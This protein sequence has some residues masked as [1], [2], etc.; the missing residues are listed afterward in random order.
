MINIAICSISGD[1]NNPLNLFC[2]D[3]VPCPDDPDDEY[4]IKCCPGNNE[5]KYC[6][7]QEEFDIIGINGTQT[8]IKDK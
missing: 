5:T 8:W 6:C 4:E 3:K 1:C 7:T 2:Y